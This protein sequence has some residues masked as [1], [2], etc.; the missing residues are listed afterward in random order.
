MDSRA[1]TPE[2]IQ[3]QSQLR[4]FYN[5]AQECNQQCVTNFESKNLGDEERD[6]ISACFKKQKAWNDL[7]VKKTQ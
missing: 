2:L 6:C 4:F 3:V 1:N 5:L 7:F